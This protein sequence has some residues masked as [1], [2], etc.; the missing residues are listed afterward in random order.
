MSFWAPRVIYGILF[1]V[2]A[3]GL[4]IVSKPGF[5][6]DSRTGEPLP[7]GVGDGKTLY[8]MGVVTVAL[9]ILTFYGFA[10]IDVIYS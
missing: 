7:F 3:T 4:L 2:L 8:S 5:V 10:L 9:A 6:F 1:Y